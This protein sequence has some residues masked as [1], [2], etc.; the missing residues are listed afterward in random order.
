MPEISTLEL[1]SQATR[2]QTGGSGPPLLFLHSEAN[3]SKWGEFHDLLAADFSVTAPVHPGF[4]GEDTPDWLEDI[5]DLVFH[6]VDLIEALELDQPLVVGSSLGGWIAADL[7]IHRSDLIS[8]AVLAGPLGLRPANPIPDIFIMEL[9]DAVGHLSNTLDQAQ[10]NP[11]TG[12]AELATQM[13]VE[14]ATQ[15]R[16]MWE[17]GYDPRLARRAHHAHCPMLVLAGERDRLLPPDH[18]PRFA[19]LF[20]ATFETVPDSGH[21]VNID[22]PGALADAVRRFHAGL[23]V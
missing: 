10:V 6:Y 7:A 19:E 22:A 14:L 9:G 8:G 1:P 20:G 16:V 23:E 13:W 5:S 21:L 3:T 2:V 11:M 18:T 12:D 4:G 17:R 15:A